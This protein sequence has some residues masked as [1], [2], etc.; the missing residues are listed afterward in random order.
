MYG[1]GRRICPGL[2]L[3]ERTMWRMTAKILWA[4]EVLPVDVDLTRY[5][6]GFFMFPLPYKVEFRPRSAAH[7]AAIRREGGVAAEFLKRF[8]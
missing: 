5:S 1:A 3:A 2:H 7:V 6:E 8:E 4:F